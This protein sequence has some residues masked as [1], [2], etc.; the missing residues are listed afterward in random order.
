M[1]VPLQLLGEF[2]SA[3]VHYRRSLQSFGKE[4][5][6][7]VHSLAGSFFHQQGRDE[8]A[9]EVWKE[10]LLLLKG[11]LDA[12]PGNYRIRFEV[13]TLHGLLGEIDQLGEEF[14]MLQETGQFEDAGSE[15]RFTI[16][17]LMGNIDAALESISSPRDLGFY[18]DQIDM[19]ARILSLQSLITSQAYL[20]YMVLAEQ[21][22]AE[23]MAIY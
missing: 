22:E 6:S 7:Y 15:Y 13:A 11:K 16:H 3:E 1:A 12:D 2:D 10:G 14:K 23:L 19:Y 9:H 18:R 8:E 5:N 20:D 21:R 17:V 4:P